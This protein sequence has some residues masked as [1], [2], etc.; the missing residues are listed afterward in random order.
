MSAAIHARLPP[1][2]L[3]AQPLRGIAAT[4][5]SRYAVTTHWIV[6]GVEPRSALSRSRAMVT[7][8]ESRMAAAPPT[9]RAARVPIAARGRWSAVLAA[10]DV[11]AMTL[12]D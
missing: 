9:M 6:V 11:V 8:V 4:R 5:A 3:C 2:L 10:I 1:I 7:T 12:L